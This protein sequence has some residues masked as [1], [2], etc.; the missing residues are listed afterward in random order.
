MSAKTT[1]HMTLTGPII[2]VIHHHRKADGTIIA[3]W[4]R[5][6]TQET[7]WDSHTPAEWED[8]VAWIIPF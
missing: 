3:R 7:W 6:D 4:Q 2:D 1:Q 5:F 8:L